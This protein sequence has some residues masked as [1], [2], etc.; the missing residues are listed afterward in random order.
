MSRPDRPAKEPR[1][2]FVTGMGAIT[3]FGLGVEALWK[4]MSSGANAIRPITRYDTEGFQCRVGGCV[5]DDLDWMER[6]PPRLRRKIDP[7]QAFAIIASEEA[8][9]QAGLDPADVDRTRFGVSAGSS[10]GGVGT[11]LANHRLFLEKGFRGVSPFTG[12]RY[13]VNGASAWP[14][15]RFGLQ[16]P[17]EAFSMTCASGNAAIGNAFRKVRD[18]YADR[19][20]AGATD[21]L[22]K[23]ILVFFHR[24]RAVARTENP[25]AID[26]LRPFDRHRKGT[27]LSE[28]AGFLL[29]E[30]E[31]ATKE[32]GATPLAEIL[33][34]GETSDAYNIVAPAP[35]G[36]AMSL[37]ISRCLQEAGL[38]PH[39]IDFVSAH[40]T[41]TLFNDPTEVEAIKAVLGEH[42]RKIPVTGPKSQLG[43]LIG[44][45]S[46]VEA[47]AGIQGG[48]EGIVTP[49]LHLKDPDPRCDLDHVPG[50]PRSHPY[51]TFLNNAFGFG[52][53]NVVLAIRTGPNL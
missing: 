48:L 2:V 22:D 39:E 1:R 14:A 36:V 23:F 8:L 41:G 18:G 20:L 13:T 10:N 21:F 45:S 9:A 51:R 42:A 24:A 5:P 6:V 15:I 53:H 4:G 30:T 52:G 35:G 38:A 17:N 49:T 3:P 32:R 43:H 16:G 11:G 25:L 29:L 44:A 50:A 12:V 31:E 27:L 19:M 28:G 33:G 37:A 46:A 47:I 40:A 26:T 34:M 7:F